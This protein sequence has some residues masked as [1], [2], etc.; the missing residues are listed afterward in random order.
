MLSPLSHIPLSL[1]FPSFSLSLLALPSSLSLLPPFLTLSPSRS[2][3]S[4]FPSFLSLLYP[5]FLLLLLFCLFL[6][7]SFALF[8]FP[9]P[10]ST[11]YPHNSPLLFLF[12]LPSFALFSLPFLVLP[13]TSLPHLLFFLF[14]FATSFP[15]FLIFSLLTQPFSLFFLFLLSSLSVLH[16]FS[17]PLSL[18][19]SFSTIT[20]SLLL[21][22]LSFSP[23]PFPVS[24][25]PPLLL[26]CQGHAWRGDSSATEGVAAPRIRFPVSHFLPSTLSPL[27]SCTSLPP[28][29]SFLYLFLSL[30][31]T[32]SPPSPSLSCV[33]L[34]LSPPPLS[35]LHLFLSF[36]TPIS[37]SFLT[38][39]LCPLSPCLIFFY[40]LSS[41]LHL[42]SFTDIFSLFSFLPLFLSIT[43]S[44]FFSP[45]SSPCLLHSSFFPSLFPL[46]P[47]PPSHCYSL[48]I[49]SF[50]F[51]SF[52]PL[53]SSHSSLLPPYYDAHPPFHPPFRFHFHPYSHHPSTRRLTQ[54]SSSRRKDRPSL[55]CQERTPFCRPI[56]GGEGRRPQRARTA[57]SHSSLFPPYY[58]AHPPFHPRFRFHFHPHSHH[59]S[60]RRLTQASSSRRQ[61]RP[62]LR[63][64]ERTPF[65]RP[66]PG[67]EGRRPQRQRLAW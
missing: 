21:P 5:F 29:H 13:T 52:L 46:S 39:F 45:H 63:C 14:I 15:F 48:F 24:F 43:F 26:L 50:L 37:L 18:S 11:S 33:Q 41:F 34:F 49:P 27:L 67:G 36:S 40:F 7:P 58:D 30:S 59:P 35:P 32:F 57:C 10:L 2:F 17:S 55:R 65:C 54:A 8:P 12:F 61:H 9:I 6:P 64:Q 3:L 51:H 28:P 62:S 53:S 56:P 42:N 66:I 44:N 22:P 1:L 19:F 25:S 38:S 60:T 4:L 31:P 23:L 16:V 47:F 20:Y